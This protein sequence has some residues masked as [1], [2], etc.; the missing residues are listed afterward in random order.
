MG[1]PPSAPPRLRHGKVTQVVLEK[2]TAHW[3]QKPGNKSFSPSSPHAPCSALWLPGVSR[4]MRTK[5][6]FQ[7]LV[8]PTSGGSVTPLSAGSSDSL[9]CVH[10]ASGPPAEDQGDLICSVPMVTKRGVCCG[11]SRRECLTVC[12]P[13]HILASSVTG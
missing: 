12:S 7:V 3:Y 4:L 10:S 5:R 13:L 6:F 9:C 1:P 11:R 8:Y 2:M